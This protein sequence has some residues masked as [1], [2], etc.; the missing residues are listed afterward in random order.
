MFGKNIKH[1]L[2][3]VIL[4]NSVQPVD[5]KAD[6][7]AYYCYKDHVELIKLTNRNFH[8]QQ[9]PKKMVV[10]PGIYN[11]RNTAL[12]AEKE[13]LYRIMFPMEENYQFIVY[14]NNLYAILTSVAWIVSHG[15]TDVRQDF[16]SLSEKA[17]SDKL[18]LTCGYVSPFAKKVLKNLGYDVHI[19]YGKMS[20]PGNGYDSEHVM[21]E[22]YDPG[23]NKWILVDLDN[24]YLF[25]DENDC[26]LDLSGFKEAL[27]QNKLKLISIAK[28]IH[29]DIS[30]FK[31]NGG[32]SFGFHMELLQTKTTI[33]EWY[34]R[35]MDILFVER[36]NNLTEDSSVDGRLPYKYIAPETFVQY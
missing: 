1:K 12:N 23:L 19:V 20:G 9:L 15:N 7:V 13:G 5:H 4:N 35:V 24:K 26:L 28:S 27:T 30:G 3:A 22:V 31:T 14:K 36:P 32:Y 16:I 21:L 25:A 33:L 2:K 34:K 11:I 10:N 8:A 6:P 17:T 29:T 18:Y